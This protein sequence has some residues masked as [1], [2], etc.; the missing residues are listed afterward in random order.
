[1]KDK[2]NQKSK[3]E[4]Q[5]QDESAKTKNHNLEKLKKQI[6]SLQQEKDETFKKLQRISA[7]YANFQKRIPKQI[8]DD[9]AYEKEKI[10]Q[11]LL[12]LIDNFEHML[13]N[14][15]SSENA[16]PLIK[17]IRIIYE[18]LLGI[19]KSYGAEQ[20]DAQGE[21]FDPALHQAML[22]KSEPELPEDIILEVFQKGYKLGDRVIRPSKVVVNKPTPQNN[23]EEKQNNENQQA[24]KETQN[25]QSE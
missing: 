5:Q 23:F 24:N 9:I 14:A 22:R 12:P 2:A 17:G 18:Q 1:M 15:V 3:K 19:L 20:I 4:K 13:Q 10:I 6:E 8:A 7:D 21:K 16:E 11:T 25:G